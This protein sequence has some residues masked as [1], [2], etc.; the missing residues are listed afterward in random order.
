MSNWLEEDD[1][2]DEARQW[3]SSDERW[4]QHRLYVCRQ[5]DKTGK[6]MVIILVELSL[7]LL[8]LSSFSL[9]LSLFAHSQTWRCTGNG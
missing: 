1:E 6:Q 8:F 3:L 5:P 2:A 7:S 9:S 4:E